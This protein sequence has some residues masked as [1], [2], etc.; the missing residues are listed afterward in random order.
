MVLNIFVIHSLFECPVTMVLN[1]FVIHS[2][3]ECPVTMV[4]NIFVIHSLFECPVTMVLNIF[5][6]HSLFECPCYATHRTNL[7]GKV[8]KMLQR[9]N[10]NHLEKQP[11]LYLYGH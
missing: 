7:A 8:I 11:E 4:L 2:L 3:F 6:I 5:V 10:L 9:K 1:I